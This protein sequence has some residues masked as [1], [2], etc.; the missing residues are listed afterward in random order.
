VAHLPGHVWVKAAPQGSGPLTDIDLL[1]EPPTEEALSVAW[2][3]EE[4]LERD[5]FL[6]YNFGRLYEKLQLSRGGSKDKIKA[7][8]KKTYGR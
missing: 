3:S 7:K 1:G 6:K 2:V 4:P 8:Q 5:T